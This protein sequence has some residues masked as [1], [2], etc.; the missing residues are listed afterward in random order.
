MVSVFRKRLGLTQGGHIYSDAS[1]ELLSRPLS[2]A[3]ASHARMRGA[4]HTL[5]AVG[6]GC[7]RLTPRLAES[8]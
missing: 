2:I 4:L 3:F 7:C 1:I 8:W 5:G 6:L